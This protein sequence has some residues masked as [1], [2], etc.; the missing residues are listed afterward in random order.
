MSSLSR[1]AAAP[2]AVALSLLVVAP[3]SA[4][5]GDRCEER[6]TMELSMPT[7]GVSLLDVMARAGSLEIE[8]VRGLS[9]IQVDATLCASNSERMEGL[10]QQLQQIRSEN[11]ALRLR[12]DDLSDQIASLGGEV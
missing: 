2:V 9:Q 5:W 11:E 3:A 6:M 8:G 4:Q 10:E 7:S 12:M 1:I